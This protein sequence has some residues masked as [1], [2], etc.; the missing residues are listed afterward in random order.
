MKD[1]KNAKKD[2]EQ[3]KE[4]VRKN[5]AKNPS[6]YV[7]NTAFGVKG[8]GYTKDAP[9]LGEGEPAKGKFKASG[10]G[11]LSESIKE[12]AKSINETGIN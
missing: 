8:M 2:V 4:L 12:I 10:Y 3:L 9:G 5:L 1:P 11:D 7:E 6:Y